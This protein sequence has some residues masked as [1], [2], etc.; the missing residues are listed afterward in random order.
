M[1]GGVI[2]TLIVGLI[3]DKGD[4]YANL[5][6]ESYLQSADDKEFWEGLS[7]EEKVM[8]EKAMNRIKESRGEAVAPPSEPAA[9]K[10]PPK[11][12]TTTTTADD[13]KTKEPQDNASESAPKDMFSDY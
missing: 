10:E 7:A 1:F 3:I 12:A 11:A 9:V 2:S 6:A 13:S 5:A 8:A 4:M